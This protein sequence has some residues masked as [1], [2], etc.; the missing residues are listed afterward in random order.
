MDPCIHSEKIVYLTKVELLILVLGIDIHQAADTS[1]YDGSWRLCN[2]PTEPDFQGSEL[3][4]LVIIGH[5]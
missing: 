3:G 5:K 1:K 4:L 2:I